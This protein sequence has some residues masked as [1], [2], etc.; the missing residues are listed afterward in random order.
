[1]K[2]FKIIFTFVALL[3][4]FAACTDKFDISEVNTGE[5]TQNNIGDTLYV[6]QNPIWGGFNKPQDMIVGREP[7]IYVADTENNRV[8]M[9]DIAGRILGAREIRR[10][11]ALAQDYQ[12]NLIV[13]GELVDAQGTVFSAVFK[14]NLVD[15]SHNIGIAK[16]DTLLPKTSFDYLKPQR[17]YTGVCVF[18]NNSFLVS[19]TGPANSNLIDPDNSLLVFS[20]KVKPDGTKIDTLT[21][22]VPLL[23]P[24]GTGLLSANGISSLTSF[25]NSSR[26]II[27]TLTGNNSFKVQ[28][29]QYVVSSD[30]EGYRSK[31]TPFESPLLTINKFG[32]PEGV[33]LDNSNNIFVA[34]A[35]KDS[36]FV[37]DSFG[38]EL[39]SFGGSNVFK[40]P[41]AVQYFNKTLYVV[42]TGNDRIVRYILSTDLN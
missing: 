1:M 13:C 14:L 11:I 36:I 16:I 23:E 28:W 8:V 41:Y 25:K 22:R 40:S 30:F 26:D 34:D 2:T 21:G 5:H 12:L 20:K 35:A 37:F 6:Q 24:Q 42:D 32:S 29:L 3:F 31:L 4:T 27:V 39:Q 38:E 17:K 18:S 15:V 19:R 33:A 10:P 7:F 9:M